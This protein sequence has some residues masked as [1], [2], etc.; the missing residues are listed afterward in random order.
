[1]TT[2]AQS[3]MRTC[4]SLQRSMSC[5][6]CPPAA[7]NHCRSAIQPPAVDPLHSTRTKAS[8]SN[9]ARLSTCPLRQQPSQGMLRLGKPAGRRGCRLACRSMQTGVPL[10]QPPVTHLRLTPACPLAA[11]GLTVC[12]ALLLTALA[13][14]CCLRGKTSSVLPTRL[15]SYQRPMQRHVK[16]I[17]CR[18]K[19]GGKTMRLPCTT[20]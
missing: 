4:S 16:Q 11:M 17:S 15:S 12:Q 6:Q 1:M 7:L 8:H 10:E 19:K 3:L 20:P 14:P 9:G 18:H 5:Q 2:S 13:Q